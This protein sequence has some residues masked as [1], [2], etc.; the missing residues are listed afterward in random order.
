MVILYGVCEC[1]F[2]VFL[3]IG[4][5]D[6]VVATRSLSLCRSVS[7][8]TPA[9]PFR[10]ICV[11]VSCCAKRMSIFAPA[12]LVTHGRCAFAINRTNGCM[13]C[14][15]RFLRSGSCYQ[16]CRHSLLRQVCR[17]SCFV[18]ISVGL[19][20]FFNCCVGCCFRGRVL[21]F[22]FPDCLPL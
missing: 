17:H 2:Y 16:R 5:W 20:L 15:Y 13:L 7:A 6:V 22:D 10:L 21:S 4:V 19:Y 18:C 12:A 3:S 11:C 8:S 9:S 14:C 1:V